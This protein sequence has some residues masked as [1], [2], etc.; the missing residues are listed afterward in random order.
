[1][2]LRYG[3]TVDDIEFSPEQKFLLARIEM[4][5]QHMSR[6]ELVAALCSSWAARFQM[7]EIFHTFCR[8]WGIG[9]RL[10]E[11]QP[12]TEIETEEDFVA[13]FGCIPTEEEAREYFRS[14][15]ET[16]TMELDMDDIVCAPDDDS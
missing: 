4:E 2:D 3:R 1:M 13:V 15:H 7:K 12:M 11:T 16:A 9:F 14:I 8:E 10:E 6:Q 5:A